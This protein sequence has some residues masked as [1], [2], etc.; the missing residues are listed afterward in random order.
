MGLPLLPVRTVMAAAVTTLMALGVNVAIAPVQ[1]TRQAG[2]PTDAISSAA[3]PADALVG[4][5]EFRTHQNAGWFYTLNANEAANAA[6]VHK[7]TRQGTVGKMRATRAP[8]TNAVHR[9]RLKSDAPSYMLT[10]SPNEINDSRF[11]DEGIVGYTDGAAR[12][13]RVRLLRFGKNGQWRV[14]LEGQEAN[15]KAAGYE[16]GGP[17]GWVAP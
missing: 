1:M 17:L 15:A 3:A 10:I 13:G 4:L 12:P 2:A 14:A 11:V 9:L 16:L 8:G 6:S 7:F 5:Q